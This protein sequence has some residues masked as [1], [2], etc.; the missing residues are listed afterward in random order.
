MAATLTRELQFALRAAAVTVVDTPDLPAGSGLAAI[1]RRSSVPIDLSRDTEPY[2]LLPRRDREW[3][4]THDIVVAA[5]VRQRG[6]ELAAVVFLGRP[7]GRLGYGRRHRWFLSMLATAAGVAWDIAQDDAG[8]VGSDD[9]LALECG[10]CGVVAK[11]RSLPCDCGASIVLAALPR[12]LEPNFEVV[13]RLGAGGIGVAYLGRDI[14]LQRDVAL[15]TLPVLQDGAMAALRAEARAMAALNHAALATIYGLECWRRTPVLVMEYF[16]GG[17]LADRLRLGVLSPEEVI[18]LG[19]SLADGLA[20]MHARGA[21][22]RD[23]KPSNI[24]YTADGVAKLFDFGLVVDEDACTGTAGY[25]PPEVLEGTPIDA[26]VDLWGLA[27][28]LR[29]AGGPD[30]VELS[31]FFTRALAP[32]RRDR[33]ESSRELREALLRLR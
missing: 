26:A 23:V 9:D 3:L 25:L 15:K 13:R 1:L 11:P 14:A 18:T 31:P 12:R 24:G 7:R 33:F 17:T 21:L 22:H 4:D 2:V 30:I 6:G 32:A 27:T 8:R 28:V 29:E 5:P 19:I 16:A 20:Y 10:G